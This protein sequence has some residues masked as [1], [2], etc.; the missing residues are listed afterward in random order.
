MQHEDLIE[1]VDLSLEK[2]QSHNF[3]EPQQTGNREINVTSPFAC[4]GM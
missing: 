4:T 1:E 3:H 2:H